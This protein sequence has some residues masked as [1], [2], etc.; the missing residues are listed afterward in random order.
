VRLAL[1]TL[2]QILQHSNKNGEKRN[3]Q[4]CYGNLEKVLFGYRY[5]NSYKLSDF[6]KPKKVL[7]RQKILP[8]D[9]KNSTFHISQLIPCGHD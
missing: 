4:F 8:G 1:P 5:L 6:F 3:E 2:Y 7:T 9:S